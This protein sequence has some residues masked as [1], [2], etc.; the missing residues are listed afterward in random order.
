MKNKSGIKKIAAGFLIAAFLFLPFQNVLAA[1]ITPFKGTGTVAVTASSVTVTGT[2]TQFT[3]TFIVGDTIRVCVVGYITADT[4]K[5]GGSDG[6]LE[7]RTIATIASNTSLTVTSAF[8]TTASSRNYV[9]DSFSNLYKTSSPNM[10]TATFKLSN[11]TV[12]NAD[13]TATNQDIIVTE[14][15]GKIQSIGDHTETIPDGTVSIDMT[16]LV[17]YPGIIDSHDHSSTT[18]SS[19]SPRQIIKTNALDWMI[20]NDCF[21]SCWAQTLTNYNER[22]QFGGY[23]H[24]A[25]NAY[26]QIFA[27]V[28]TLSDF[29]NAD[30]RAGFEMPI[31]LSNTPHDTEGVYNVEDYAP[32]PETGIAWMARN[33]YN[34]DVAA[35]N[36][37]WAVHV[38]EGSDAATLTQL[39]TVKISTNG[40]HSNMLLVHGTGFSDQDVIDTINAGASISWTPYSIWYIVD[41]V[42]NVPHWLTL[43]GDDGNTQVNVSLSTDG[44]GSGSTNMLDELKFAKAMEPD[45]T[46]LDLFK[47]A[48]INGAKALHMDN[49]DSA[50]NTG[51]VIG[52]GS[53]VAG[54]YADILISSRATSGN[55]YDDFVNL[56]SKDIALLL[57]SGKPV[58]GNSTYN[59]ADTFLP[60]FNTNKYETVVVDGTSKFVV[61]RPTDLINAVYAKLGYYKDFEFMPYTKDPAVPTMPVPVVTSV[62]VSGNSI[63]VASSDGGTNYATNYTDIT[64][65]GTTSNTT[66]DLAVNWNNSLV[67]C[68]AGQTTWSYTPTYSASYNPPPPE[69]FKTKQGINYFEFRAKKFDGVTS[70]SGS[71]IFSKFTKKV[72]TI[73]ATADTP[74]NFAATPASTTGINLSWDAVSGATNYKVYRSDSEGGSY[75]NIGDTA[76][77][78][79]SDTGLNNNTTYYYKITATNADIYSS[80]SSIA[81]ATTATLAIPTGFSA[82]TAS[83]T[84]I[85]LTWD[86]ISGATGYNVYRSDTLSG[87]YSSIATPSSASYNDTG[88]TPGNTYFYKVKATNA[89]GESALA[90][91]VYETAL[92]TTPANFLATTAS[93]T[94]INLSWDGSSGAT[95]YRIYRSDTSGGTYSSIA[96]PSITSYSDT[97][98]T[99]GATYYYKI[100]AVNA[101]GNS[102]ESSIING[103]ATPLPP[104]DF[105][106][107]PGDEETVLTW[108]SSDNATG[109]KIYKDNGS[110]FVYLNQTAG[111]TFTDTG[112]TNGTTY[113]YKVSATGNN[114][115]ESSL[116][117]AVT[118]ALLPTAPTNLATEPRSGEVLLTWTASSDAAKYY[119]YRKNGS[120]Y[121]YIGQ[122]TGTN[123]VDTGLDNGT[124][125]YY[126]ISSIGNNDE[127]S[128]LVSE[129]SAALQQSAPTNLSASAGDGQAELAWN[130]ATNAAKY[131]IYRKNGDNYDYLNQTTGIAFTDTGLTNGTT[132]YYK[133]SAIGSNDTESSLISTS[134]ALKPR[135]ASI[136]LN[137]GDAKTTNKTITIT[138]S[139]SGAA[140]MMVSTDSGFSDASWE[141][142]SSSKTW[143]FGN[144]GTKTIYAKFQGANETISDTAS[145]SIK[146]NKK[147]SHKSSSK[148]KSKK[149]KTT[150]TSIV[151]TKNKTVVKI[152]N[153][154]LSF[155]ASP[156]SIKRG[157]AIT[158][159]WT[160]SNATACWASGGNWTGWKTSSNGV[161]SASIIPRTS[162]TYRIECWN[163]KGVSSGAKSVNIK[164]KF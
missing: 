33:D 66:D 148:K 20:A 4:C 2:S 74:T 128:D 21:V 31:K 13:S 126:K 121:D 93:T 9:Y 39:D 86:A 110:S 99:P 81:N 50:Q 109:Y 3:T 103:T 69:Q 71:G 92:S 49:V 95:S 153:P 38:E 51:G 163:S 164:V 41:W 101:G 45:L 107:T 16:G 111:T 117:D 63:D 112:L 52:T 145:D 34:A 14:S 29:E 140:L 68:A 132:Y 158:L 116:T 159:K 141:S 156:K 64:F 154:T 144:T 40:L 35:G 7:T 150:S 59:T 26:K 120:N 82:T 56:E 78:S 23:S 135:S 54:K 115:T 113:S 161:H 37:V 44:T 65:N 87:T 108:T 1:S 73:L 75:T 83:T 60:Y 6:T 130:A 25:L 43:R 119:I 5:N 30:Y 28:T 91:I 36:L 62:K 146:I 123:Y 100:I 72:V 19:H 61:S 98:R 18:W 12:V 114:S 89:G 42:A 70:N 137:N 142:F 151:S 125:Y 80:D 160:S 134:V 147:S 11:L 155:S 129:V 88:R 90:S 162:A 97:G 94:Q 138:L 48:T 10:N 67:S 105:L 124:T 149:K 27:G 76:S 157:K 57:S 96:T 46:G 136:I 15:D 22:T 47:M 106:A 84:Q 131:Y 58:Y 24:P 53:L 118:S 32:D 79:Y 104:A 122:T 102:A 143:V 139:V 85:N 152:K 55:L 77:N 17:A 133:V 8:T 127:E